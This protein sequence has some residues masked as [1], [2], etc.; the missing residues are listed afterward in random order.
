MNKQEFLTKIADLA[1]EYERTN[2]DNTSQPKI[3]GVLVDFRKG[4]NSLY[5]WDGTSFFEEKNVKLEK[6]TVK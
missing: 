2:L 1:E 4:D 6:T 5:E 3:I